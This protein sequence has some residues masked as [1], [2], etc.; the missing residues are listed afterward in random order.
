MKTTV[1]SSALLFVGGVATLGATE[2]VSAD[3]ATN[4]FDE[5]GSIAAVSVVV[6]VLRSPRCLNCHPPGNAPTQGDDRRPHEQHVVRGPGADKEPGQGAPTLRCATC[7]H[8]S[9]SCDLS[10]GS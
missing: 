9:N 5:E 8:A 2:S 3:Q 1:R 7:H 10:P 6:S 4:R